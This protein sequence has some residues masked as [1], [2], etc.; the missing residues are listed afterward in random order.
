MSALEHELGY[1]HEDE[2][3]GE[4]LLGTLGSLASSL[5]GEDELAA[6]DEV[7]FTEHGFLEQ[8]YFEDEAQG[9]GILGSIGSMLGGLL[10]EDEIAGEFEGLGESEQFFGRL[11][12]LIRRAMPA[13]T[14]VARVAVPM[15]A[16]AV[17]GPLG[18]ILGKMA[19]QFLG[20]A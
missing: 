10:G 13:L 9:E 3:Q 16:G 7:G 20:E 2:A 18:G 11:R 17:G 15:V 14:S 8:G 6:E 19:G 12:G 4:G 5:L 1:M